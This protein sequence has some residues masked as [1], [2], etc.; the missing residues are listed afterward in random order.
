MQQVSGAMGGVIQQVAG[1]KEFRVLDIRCQKLTRCLPLKRVAVKEVPQQRLF[2]VDEL[3][4][5]L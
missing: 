1:T 2:D 5:L 3:L 4:F